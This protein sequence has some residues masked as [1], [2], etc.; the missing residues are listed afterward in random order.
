MLLGISGCQPIFNNSDIKAHEE[1]SNSDNEVESSLDGIEN[2]YTKIAI[3]NI[4]RDV[5]HKFLENPSEEFFCTDDCNNYEYIEGKPFFANNGSQI[6]HIDTD[7]VKF[8]ND[9]SLIKDFLSKHNISGDVERIITFWPPR[10][11]LTIWVKIDGASV[12]LQVEDVF[13]EPLNYQYSVISYNDYYQ[14][15]SPKNATLNVNGNIIETANNP[16]IYYDYCEIPFLTTLEALG[17]TYKWETNS[18]VKI[19]YNKIYHLDTENRSL[20]S[21]PLSNND[22]LIGLSGINFFYTVDEDCMISNDLFKYALE[23]MGKK[24][25]IEIDT[26]NNIISIT[27]K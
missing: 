22:L 6:F 5:F 15:F 20:Y 9:K 4:S 27:E 3:Y 2:S 26:E 18:E 7:F 25:S 16:I 13:E 8:V 23:G 10:A 21:E 1:A 17:A 12:F 24:V 19:T 11:P 14:K